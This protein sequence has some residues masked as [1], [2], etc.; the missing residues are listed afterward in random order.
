MRHK[1]SEAEKQ[2]IRANCELMTDSQIAEQLTRITKTNI[3]KNIIQRYRLSMGIEKDRGRSVNRVKPT[4]FYK[5]FM[6]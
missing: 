4:Q 1:L 2:Y 3:S 5:P 6:Y